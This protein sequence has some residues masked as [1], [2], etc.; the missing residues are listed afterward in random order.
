MASLSNLVGAFLER[1]RLQEAA[2]AAEAAREADR[3][4]SSLLSSVSHEFKTPLAALT[5]T[6]SNLLESDVAW[7]EQSARDELRSI[8]A[9]V[10]R[11]NSSISAL[12][13]LSRLEARAWEP[14]REP[15]EL[16]EIVDAGIDTLPA[17][18]RERVQVQLPEQ[19]LV[20]D[21]DFVQWTRVVQN[22]LE[23][24][25]CTRRGRSPSA[26]AAGTTAC[27]S[28]SRTKDRASPPTNTKRCSRSSTEARHRP[29][30]AVG[31]RPGP[32]DRPR[33][34]AQPRRDD[35][36]RTC[37]AR[38]AVRDHADPS[39][40]RSGPRT[41]RAHDGPERPTH[42]LVVD[43]E[44][45][46][47]RALRSILST[48]GYILDMASTGERGAHQGHR[49]P[50]RSRGPRPDAARQIAASRSAASSAPG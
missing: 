50:A 8:V 25:C 36:W 28:G 19:D 31:H 42:V 27:V 39:A 9:D 16:G 29:Q 49:R 20:V 32:G 14:R 30:R 7:D 6:V 22:L 37:A 17:H 35:P 41:R 5:A 33:D 18:L 1:Q 13:E 47:R 4:K 44:E 15:Y 48:R 26:P 24:A 46:I 2:T 3:L 11:L 10:A 34:R 38:R 21:V 40:S 45:Q 43:D 12:L 23:N